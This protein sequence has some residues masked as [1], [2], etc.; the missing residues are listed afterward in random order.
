MS[1]KIFFTNLSA[2]KIQILLVYHVLN[3]AEKYAKQIIINV[4]GCSGKKSSIASYKY[5]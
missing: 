2:F 3:I 1:I 5:S 4:Y